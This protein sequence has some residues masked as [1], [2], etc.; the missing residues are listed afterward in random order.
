M[1]KKRLED[2]DNPKGGKGKPP[3]LKGVEASM[4]PQDILNRMEQLKERLSAEQDQEEANRIIGRIQTLNTSYMQLTGSDVPN[5]AAAGSSSGGS[6]RT[7]LENDLHKHGTELQAAMA[8]EEQTR[9]EL[10]EL[11]EKLEES[12]PHIQRLKQERETCLDVVRKLRDAIEGINAEWQEKFDG[13]KSAMDAWAAQ[14]DE[15]MKE[16][17]APLQ[18]AA[19]REERACVFALGRAAQ[20]G[21]CSTQ[22][23]GGQNG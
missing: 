6:I 5:G 18:T 11:Q 12:A 2:M 15:V 17:C 9:A 21:F 4:Q 3:Q 8:R 20:R 14:R 23:P 1:T 13:Y 22:L 16:R 7:A 19:R 10:N